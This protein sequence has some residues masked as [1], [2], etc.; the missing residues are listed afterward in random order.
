MPEKVG[1]DQLEQAL[2]TTA[3]SEHETFVE[4]VIQAEEIERCRGRNLI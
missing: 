2:M 1:K 4:V 3:A